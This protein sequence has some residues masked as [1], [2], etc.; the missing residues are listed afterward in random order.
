MTVET[1]YYN[2]GYVITENIIQVIKEN[3]IVSQRNQYN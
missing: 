3:R 2:Q 1:F